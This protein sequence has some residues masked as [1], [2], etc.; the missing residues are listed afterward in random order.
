MI[1]GAKFYDQDTTIFLHRASKIIP[2]TGATTAMSTSFLGSNDGLEL[3]DGT[4]G[5]LLQASIDAVDGVNTDLKDRATSQL[6]AMKE[7]L[8][9]AVELTPGDRLSMDTKVKVTK[10]P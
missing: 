4:G 3:L 6:L 7:T 8:K 9:Q 5:Y 1:E 10:R 2:P